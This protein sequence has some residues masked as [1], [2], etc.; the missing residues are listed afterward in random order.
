MWSHNWQAREEPLPSPYWLC[1]YH[2]S[3]VRSQC[4]GLLLVLLGSSCSPPALSGPLSQGAFKLLSAILYCCVVS[5]HPSYRTLHLP[6]LNFV[7][8]L[9]A[10]PPILSGSLLGA[11]LPFGISTLSFERWPWLQQVFH[12]PCNFSVQSVSAWFGYKDTLRCYVESYATAK[13]R[14]CVLLSLCPLRQTSHYGK[15][16]G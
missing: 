4:K 8:F 7:R 1:I 3:L 6:K 11:A 15:Q 14:K 16:S 2:R 10:H 9:S 5:F 12:P 13:E